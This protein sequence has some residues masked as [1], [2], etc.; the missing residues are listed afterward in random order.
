VPV[1]RIDTGEIEPALARVSKV[2]HRPIELREALPVPRGTEDTAR[3]QHRA[4]DLATAL[5]VRVAPLG[6][7]KLVGA[8]FEGTPVAMPN[9]DATI[10]VTDVDMFAPNSDGV[11]HHL[12]PTKKAAVISV[13][14]LREAFYRRKADPK[15]QR[16]RLVKEI[17]QAIG[18]L[19]GLQ[20][21][22][23]SQ[24]V[25]STTQVL[26]DIDRKGERFCGA[27]WRRIS[28]GVSRF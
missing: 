1:G 25:L 12:L 3:G 21:C 4:G 13:K 5:A 11:W 7:V 26:Q 20:D 28:T 23:D 9:P 24:C 8:T 27:C 6:V 17:L 10:F 14:R 2:I 18:R 15:K 16:L 19:S 22:R